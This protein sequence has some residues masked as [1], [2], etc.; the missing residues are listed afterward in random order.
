MAALD[1]NVLVRYLVEDEAA[2]S[3]A[4]RR[5]IRSA[6]RTNEALFVPVTVMLE[7][8]WVL[9]SSFGFTKPDVVLALSQL[10]SSVELSFGSEA[11]LEVA[12]ALY[13]RSAA[14]FSDCVHVALA[15]SADQCPLWTF[16][17]VA[18]KVDGAKLL[19]A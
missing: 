10:L 9:R 17:K 11:A 15:H 19:T 2:Q 3:A 8:E 14:D 16:D 5:L 18:S 13:Q 7:L 12:L 4:A 1:T 6:V